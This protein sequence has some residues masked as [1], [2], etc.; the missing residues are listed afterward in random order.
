MRAVLCRDYTGIDG[1]EIGE[2]VLAPLGPR[3]VRIAIAAAGINFADLLMIEG[4]Y[5]QRPDP[6]FSP[7]LE[8]AGTIVECGAEVTRVKPGDR[9]AAVLGHGGYAEAVVTSEDA[10]FPIPDGMDF[11]V[12]GAFPVVYGTSHM[13]LVRRARLQAGEVLLVLGASGGVGLT[14][15]EIGKVV[16]ATVIAAASTPEKLAL[17]AEFGADHGIDYSREDLRERVLELTDGRGADVVYDPVGGAAFNAALRCIAWE[18]RLLVVGF[19]SGEIPT[20]PANRLLLKNCAAVGVFWGAYSERD[21]SVVADSL[22]E[23]FDWY[24]DGRLKPQAAQHFDLAEA[25]EALT[26][27]RTRKSRGKLVLTTADRA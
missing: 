25:A 1:L 26:L 5:Q 12:A 15:V 7:G 23:M 16:G 18:G 6:P 17:A 10:V 20:I 8:A 3:R 24:M 14:A 13:G 19:A 2:P 4:K 27:M 22:M 21:R 9:V 11:A